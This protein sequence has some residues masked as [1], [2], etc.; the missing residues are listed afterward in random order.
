MEPD[1]QFAGRERTFHVALS[2][3]RWPGRGRFRLS[4]TPEPK[5]SL[6]MSRRRPR[7][8]A[9]GARTNLKR[10]VGAHQSSIPFHQRRDREKD[11]AF[12]SVRVF[13]AHYYWLTSGPGS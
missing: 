12:E 13:S 6:R 11:A 1:H 2:K 8:C 4:A 10:D 9:H 5:L 7:K 3:P